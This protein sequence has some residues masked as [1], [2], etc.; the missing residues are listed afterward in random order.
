MP[1]QDLKYEIIGNNDLR[2]ADANGCG[3]AHVA[4]RD[5]DDGDVI[6]IN[7]DDVR[8]LIARLQAHADKYKL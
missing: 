2:F 5:S 4:L 1:E 7:E 6:I 8:A 3:F